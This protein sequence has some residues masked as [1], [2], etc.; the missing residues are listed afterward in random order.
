MIHMRAGLFRVGLF[1]FL[2]LSGVTRGYCQ[3]VVR[4]EVI[5][6]NSSAN[7]VIVDLSHAD[8]NEVLDIQAGRFFSQLKWN[9]IYIFSFKKPGFVSKVIEFSTKVPEDF[10]K[11]LLQPY[12]LQVRLFPVFEGV[13]TVFFE[14]PVAKIRFDEALRDFSDD[15]DYS[16]QVRYKVEEMR[17]KGREVK[18]TTA[19]SGKKK[20]EEKD[21]SLNKKHQVKSKETATS[22]QE[23]A[24]TVAAKQ[25]VK[26]VKEISNLHLPP[27][28]KSYPNGKTVE[29]FDLEGKHIVRTIF[30]DG[31]FRRVL[32]LVTHDWG[33]IYYFID[34]LHIGNR[35][36][37]REAYLAE[38]ENEMHYFKHKE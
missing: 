30:F 20:P 6:D 23:V 17:R 18:K 21:R 37:T 16:L 13:D 29:E 1:F 28:K 38:I 10:P 26:P 5:C 14:K 3:F 36:I 8:V 12:L 9:Q 35:C 4:G 11:E 15:R 31:D 7:D 27:L 34:E 22:I 2:F 25:E 19:T 24:I 33:A 32:V